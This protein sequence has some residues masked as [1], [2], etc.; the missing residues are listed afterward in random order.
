MPAN[1]TVICVQL[2]LSDGVLAPYTFQ[3]LLVHDPPRSVGTNDR[4]AN[5]TRSVP[6]PF[7]QNVT[8]LNAL[9]L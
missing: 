2:L 4:I 5:S 9:A 1:M 3:Q 6:L 7:A 8:P